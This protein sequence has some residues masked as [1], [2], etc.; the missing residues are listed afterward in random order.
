MTES[1]SNNKASS[2][3]PTSA[4]LLAAFRARL[5]ESEN[6]GDLYTDQMQ[7]ARHFNDLIWKIAAILVPVSFAG[8]ALTFED[9][10][11]ELQSTALV[12]TS[13]GSSGLLLFWCLF[14]EWHRHL[15]KRTFTLTGLIEEQWH[16]RQ[17]S[18]DRASLRSHLLDFLT[19]VDY[20]HYLRWSLLSAG[21]IGWALKVAFS[22]SFPTGGARL[23]CASGLGCAGLIVL[24]VMIIQAVRGRRRSATP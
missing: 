19:P 14:A 21:F 2:D 23:W 8:F 16:L 5:A 3:T 15:W 22:S 9:K 7:W 10:N 20:G 4:D 11:G 12:F 24:I 1:T 17:P 13:L 18:D 6:L